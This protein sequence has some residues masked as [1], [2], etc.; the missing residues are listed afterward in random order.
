MLIQFL[1][2]VVLCVRNH[3]QQ[4]EEGWAQHLLNQAINCNV[5]V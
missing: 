4:E 2:A 1:D 5:A 3:P